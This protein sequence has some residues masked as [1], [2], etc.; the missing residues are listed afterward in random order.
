MNG[1]VIDKF[2]HQQKLKCDIPEWCAFLHLH[3]AGR[4]SLGTVA[5]ILKFSFSLTW[6]VN[7]QLQFVSSIAKCNTANFILWQNMETK[8]ATSIFSQS[9]AYT[10]S[11]LPDIDR[12]S[13]SSDFSIKN[14]YPRFFQLSGYPDHYRSPFEIFHTFMKYMFKNKIEIQ[15]TL[16]CIIQRFTTNE[17][18]R[19]H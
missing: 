1:T 4:T 14:I 18:L 9:F 8:C 19:N 2:K 6:I 16:V 11:F 15:T 5:I 13:W 12:F 3:V 17:R 7:P 10:I